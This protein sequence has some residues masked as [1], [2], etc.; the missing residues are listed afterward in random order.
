MVKWLVVLGCVL[1][2]A[3][4]R[5]DE[6]ASDGPPP[7][8]PVP[9]VKGPPRMQQFGISIGAANTELEGHERTLV[10]LGAQWGIVL[11]NRLRGVVEY[12][13]LISA[14]TDTT[15]MMEPT[16]GRGHS[17]RLGLR[18]N[19]VK[20]VIRDIAKLYADVEVAGGAIYVTDSEVGTHVLPD[21]TA[22]VRL[23]YELWSHEATSQASI[24]DAHLLFGALATRDHV[25]FL[26]GLGMEWGR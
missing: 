20:K 15:Q 9:T 19:V 4:A 22:A 3:L 26:F 24:F 11:T 21:A 2:P 10:T 23:G 1:A 12:E 16:R 18:V 25:G 8:P 17:G 7:P 13:W 6:I 5:A 14:G